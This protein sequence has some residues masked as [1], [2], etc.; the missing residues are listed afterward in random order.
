[1]AQ[2]LGIR[3]T[4][5]VLD[6][7]TILQVSTTETASGDGATIID[8]GGGGQTNSPVSHFDMI[9]DISAFDLTT[10]DENVQFILE[11]SSSAT[12]ASTIQ[13]LAAIHVTGATGA[14]GNVDV[15]DSTGRFVVPGTNERNGTTYRY[16]RLTWIAGGTTPS[17]TF[18]ASLGLRVGSKT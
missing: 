17:A 3:R 1:M 8:L 5:N 10:G 15:A 6:T 14:P 12:F 7:Q 13:A 9:I 11:G 16:V 4:N 2:G 18:T